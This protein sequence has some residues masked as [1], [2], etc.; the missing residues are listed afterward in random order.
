MKTTEYDLSK[1]SVR[2]SQ[3]YTFAMAKLVYIKV[4]DTEKPMALHADKVETTG[5]IGFSGFA[6]SISRGDQKIGEFSGQVVEG[7]WIEEE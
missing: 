1:P 2:I 4:K 6:V 5:M 7:W 3:V